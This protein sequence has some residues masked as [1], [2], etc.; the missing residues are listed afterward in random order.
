MKRLGGFDAMF[1]HSETP[2]L[3]QHTLKVGILDT[4]T[5]EAEYTTDLFRQS[6][7]RRLHLLDPFRYRL[8]DVPLKIHRP[9]WVE[10]VDVDLEYHVRR[11]LIRP[12][13]GRR[14]L[15]EVIAD[16][17]ST[18][19]DRQ[20]PLW[21]FHVIEGMADNKIAIVGKI[22]H[23]LADGVA[24]ANLIARALDEQAMIQG[25]SAQVPVDPP[26]SRR[27]VL[28]TALGDHV[29]Q[30]AGLPDLLRYTADG[31]SSLQRNRRI[32]PGLARTFRAPITFINHTVAPTRRFASTTL[33]LADV[34]ATARKLGGTVND[35]VL[36][37]SSGALR[38]LLIEHDGSANEPL[39]ALVP[40][41]LNPSPE[42]IFGN[43][44]ATMI[45][46]LPVHVSDPLERMRMARTAAAI[47]KANHEALG[48]EILNRWA[49]Y[50]P[51]FLARPGLRRLS[52]RE[53]QNRMANV[54]ISNV[55]GPRTRGTVAGASLEEIYSV[56]PLT[57]GSGINITV[58][59]YVDQLNISVLEDGITVDDPHLI[60]DAMVAEYQ[61]IRHAAGLPTSPHL[62]G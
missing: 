59:S 49:E 23:V 14:E 58:W 24:S 60:T 42:R 36:A 29:R 21:E 44:F 33:P 34:K 41:S 22:H 47:A 37:I 57:P 61:T 32:V 62:V 39:L 17:A 11:H 48:P 15:D 8:V 26:P 6:L 38:T 45:V 52:T 5:C 3:T 51:A 13:A 7:G 12:P 46:S 4:T 43:D 18:P 30:L 54:S 31:V 1:L 35:L 19:L 20:R 16:I 56:G 55:P 10:N 40:R 28:K 25:E 9:M 27:Q 53:A 2:N 50:I